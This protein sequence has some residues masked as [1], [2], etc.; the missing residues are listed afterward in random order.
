MSLAVA[1]LSASGETVIEDADELSESFPGFVETL[2]RLGA[3][4]GWHGSTLR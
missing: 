3:N 4:I 1:G 2:Q